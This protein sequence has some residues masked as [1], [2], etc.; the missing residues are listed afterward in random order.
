MSET[1]HVHSPT[2]VATNLAIPV[3][4]FR[5]NPSGPILDEVFRTAIDARRA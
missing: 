2:P 5:P 1:D 3:F 4:A